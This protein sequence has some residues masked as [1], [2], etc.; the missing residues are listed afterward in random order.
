MAQAQ[1]QTHA[2]LDAPA[3]DMLRAGLVRVT[4]GRFEKGATFLVFGLVVHGDP[5][6]RRPPCLSAAARLPG[7]LTVLAHALLALLARMPHPPPSV[8]T[9]P[10][11]TAKSSS[12]STLCLG[13]RPPYLRMFDA[14]PRPLDGT[15]SSDFGPRIHR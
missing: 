7:T 12:A 14:R 4:H 2:R 11:P 13:D 8:R 15:R 6:Y 5:A 10:L 1:R 9:S 3:D